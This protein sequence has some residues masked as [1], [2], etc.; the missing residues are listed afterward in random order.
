MKQILVL[1]ISLF[2]HICMVSCG[3]KN[4]PV[5]ISQAVVKCIEK[6]D[7]LGIAEYAYDKEGSKQ[8]YDV[9]QKAYDDPENF[10]NRHVADRVKNLVEA[11][12]VLGEQDINEETAKIEFTMENKSGS[13]SSLQ[14][15]LE[16]KDGQWYA[17]RIM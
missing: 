3:V 13:T 9:F 15:V 14:V 1:C 10:P 11:K 2:I 7:F 5:E 16:K 4:D 8:C 6:G 17:N 12:Y